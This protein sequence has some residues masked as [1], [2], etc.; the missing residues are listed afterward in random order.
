MA[1]VSRFMVGQVMVGSRALLYK[2]IEE[3]YLSIDL[4]RRFIVIIRLYIFCLNFCHKS[5]YDPFK[6]RLSMEKRSKLSTT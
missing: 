3:I 2:I 1:T 5:S 4:K 6:S